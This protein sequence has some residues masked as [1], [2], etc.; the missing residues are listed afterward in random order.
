MN[1]LM[2]AYV[3]SMDLSPPSED[4]D[5]YISTEDTFSPVIHRINQVIRWRATHPDSGIPPVPEILYRYS[6]PPAE[7]LERSKPHLDALIS[8]CDVKPVEQKA[9][10]RR[11]REQSKPKS[12]IN[13]DELLG[14]TSAQKSGIKITLE[15]AIPDYKQRISAEDADDEV[16]K[17]ATSEMFELV[18]ELIKTSLGDLNYDR[19]RSLLA[20]AREEMGKLEFFEV[21]NDEIKKLKTDVLGEKLDGDRMELWYQLKKYDLGLLEGPE[22]AGGVTWKE[23]KEVSLFVPW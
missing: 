7:L 13:I 20:A 21:Y 3:D 17:A 22:E 10:S 15:N 4:A 5:E 6:K 18:R 16:M 11:A 19:A 23:A 1:S 14:T 12:G 2:S 9:K 8:A